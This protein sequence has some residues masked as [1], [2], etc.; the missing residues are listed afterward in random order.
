M[1]NQ[2]STVETGVSRISV[3][4]TIKCITK[5]SLIMVALLMF[6][7]GDGFPP[8]AKAHSSNRG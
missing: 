8:S 1:I 4:I 7:Y 3:K 5:V 2:F 6:G